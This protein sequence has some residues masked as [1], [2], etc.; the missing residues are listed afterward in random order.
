MAKAL[1]SSSSISPMHTWRAAHRVV[2]CEA[3]V[4]VSVVARLA[5]GH[6]FPRGFIGNSGLARVALPWVELR[7]RVLVHREYTEPNGDGSEPTFD[8]LRRFRRI[9]FGE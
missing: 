6:S 8:S 2:V 9:F 7:F 5:S 1:C 4:A 3:E